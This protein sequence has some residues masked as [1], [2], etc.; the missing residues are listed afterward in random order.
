M[1]ASPHLSPGLPS[2]LFMALLAGATFGWPATFA[3]LVL[4]GLG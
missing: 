3:N 1:G 4:F 2:R